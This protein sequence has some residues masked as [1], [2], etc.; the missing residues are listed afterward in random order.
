MGDR[1]SGPAVAN[2]GSATTVQADW[3]ISLLPPVGRSRRTVRLSTRLDDGNGR[4]LG[5][6]VID[7]TIE[8][9][10]PKRDPEVVMGLDGIFEF[11]ATD[12][13]RL[14]AETRKS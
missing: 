13:L 4:D 5:E 7:V 9:A 3:L 10:L 14:A 12:L 11:V 1:G 8:A 6:L 2:G